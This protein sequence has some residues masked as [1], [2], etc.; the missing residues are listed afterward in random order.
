MCQVIQGGEGC[1]FGSE[2]EAEEDPAAVARA[3]VAHFAELLRARDEAWGSASSFARKPPFVR[4]GTN[5]SAPA[6]R[7]PP[8]SSS[9][10]FGQQQP[11]VLAE[12]W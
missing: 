3:P 7:A 8:P 6:F 10:R 1:W 5:S 12:K 2:V 4:V 9:A 11:T